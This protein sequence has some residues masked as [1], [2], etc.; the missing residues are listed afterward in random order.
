MSRVHKDSQLVRRAINPR[1]SI[2]GN[3]VITPIPVSGKIRDRHQFDRIDAEPLQMLKPLDNRC[4]FSRRRK[5]P[6][7]QLINDK[8]LKPGSGPCRVRPDKRSRINNLGRTVHPLGLKTRSEV[9][10]EI[11]IDTILVES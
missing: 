9:R 4:E 7:M 6:D 3:A 2:N 11:A 10:K 5:G 1:W 8:F